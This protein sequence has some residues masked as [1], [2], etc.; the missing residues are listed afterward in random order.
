MKKIAKP[1]IRFARFLNTLGL[2]KEHL[3]YDDVVK[4]AQKHLPQAQMC[5]GEFLHVVVRKM[6]KHTTVEYGCMVNSEIIQCFTSKG[7]SV[8]VKASEVKLYNIK[9][10]KRIVVVN[11]D[12]GYKKIIEGQNPQGDEFDIV[13]CGGRVWGNIA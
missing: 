12:E 5:F 6:G 8:S 3:S 7:E 11:H 2:N 9:I 13:I 4:M 10:A 1:F